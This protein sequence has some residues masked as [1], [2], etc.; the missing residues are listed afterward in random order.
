MRTVE[1]HNQFWFSELF[2]LL[3]SCKTLLNQL[4][5]L[6]GHS[7]SAELQQVISS[8]RQM[9]TG[10]EDLYALPQQTTQQPPLQE[11][12]LRLHPSRRELRTTGEVFCET[13]STKWWR[14]GEGASAAMSQHQSNKLILLRS[15]RV[16][17]PTEERFW[18]RGESISLQ[19][20]DSV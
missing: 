19:G 15:S 13:S 6:R 2:L 11:L 3:F 20:M 12:N 16:L 1:S 17:I 4:I 8:L 18:G 9:S 10:L 14:S 7:V 5:Y